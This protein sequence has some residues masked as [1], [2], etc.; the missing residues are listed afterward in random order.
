MEHSHEKATE[1]FTIAETCEVNAREMLNEIADSMEAA[2]K[3]VKTQPYKNEDYSWWAQWWATFLQEWSCKCFTMCVSKCGDLR[4]YQNVQ[5][6][7]L[8]DFERLWL[9]GCDIARIDRLNNM[10]KGMSG[11]LASRSEPVSKTDEQALWQWLGSFEEAALKAIDLFKEKQRRAIKRSLKDLK[12]YDEDS[13]EGKLK[14]FI[15][16]LE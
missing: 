8:S 9:V 14:R 11:S 6:L 2:N 1:L 10:E 16:I 4:E 7:W 5:N 12:E 15:S 13:L 3:L